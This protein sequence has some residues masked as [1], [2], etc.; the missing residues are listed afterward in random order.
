MMVHILDDGRKLV[1]HDE[2]TIRHCTDTR[3]IVIGYQQL[4][5]V[6]EGDTVVDANI[7]RKWINWETGSLHHMDQVPA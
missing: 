2:E 6:W 4:I 3:G 7:V 5:E 1:A